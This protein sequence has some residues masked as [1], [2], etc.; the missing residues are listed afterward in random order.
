MYKNFL[1]KLSTDLVSNFLSLISTIS[2]Y[3]YWIPLSFFAAFSE[4]TLRDMKWLISL[5]L[6]A[7]VQ[8]EPNNSSVTC[9]HGFSIDGAC[10]CDWGWTVSNFYV[11]LWSMVS[12]STWSPKLDLWSLEGTLCNDDIDECLHS[13]C[14]SGSTCLNTDGSYECICLEG[15]TGPLCEA[16]SCGSELKCSFIYLLTL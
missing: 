6:L 8:S 13:P 11:S 4:K 9:D 1:F 10:V 12:T 5:A 16:G 15:R 3:L 2:S 14:S 7:G